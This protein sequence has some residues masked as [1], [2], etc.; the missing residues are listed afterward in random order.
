MSN[1]FEK[2]NLQFA[3][4]PKYIPLVKNVTKNF[5]IAFWFKSFRK[6][7]GLTAI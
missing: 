3:A 2:G 5:T 4:E 1:P 7:A 6:N